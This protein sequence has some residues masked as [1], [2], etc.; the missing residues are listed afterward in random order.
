MSAASEAA[1]STEV[2]GEITNFLRESLRLL[3][4]LSVRYEVGIDTAPREKTIASPRD[5]ADYLYAELSA[6][7]QEQLR[8]I[9]LDTRNHLLGVQLV[10]QGSANQALIDL[11][12]LYREAVR[13]NAAAII[14]A[15]NHPSGDPTPSPQDVQLTVAAGKAGALLGI[16]LIDHVVIGR[17]DFVSLRELGLYSPPLAP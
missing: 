4:E 7:P 11:R 2:S 1:R 13:V 15:H 6:L 14:L 8:A 9:L 3:G 16:E 10:A 17:P 5:A 12:D